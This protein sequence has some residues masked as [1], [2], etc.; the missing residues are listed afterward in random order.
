M[1][2]LSARKLLTPYIFSRQ[3]SGFVEWYGV[4]AY[5]LDD[6]RALLRQYGYEIDPDDPAVSVRE[7]VVLTD[8]EV[9]HIGPNMG[10]VQ[11]RGVWYPRH[12]LGD[13][14]AASRGHRD[15]VT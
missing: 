9:R 11:L 15:R 2:D 13:A 7:R 1:S 14:A 12:N 8:E 6:A 4:S 5:S 10:P 3:R